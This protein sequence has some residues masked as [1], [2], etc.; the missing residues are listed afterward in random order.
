M[1]ITEHFSNTCLR[2]N[3]KIALVDIKK[4]YTFIDIYNYAG[5]ISAYIHKNY[6]L[7]GD[8]IGISINGSA[9]S[10]ILILGIICS[11]NYYIPINSENPQ[12]LINETIALTNPKLLLSPNNCKTATLIPSGTPLV[13]INEILN[14]TQEL[15]FKNVTDE[16][17]LYAI[18]TSGSTGHPKIILKNHLSMDEFII[19]FTHCFD[20]DETENIGNQIPFYSDAAQKE[21]YLLIYTGCRIT[22][23]PQYYFA[24]PYALVSYINSHNITILPWVPSAFDVIVKFNILKKDTFNGLKC[25]FWVGERIKRT[26]I[27]YWRNHFPHV[28]HV[29]IYGM[30]EL[31]GIC[32]YYNMNTELP[33]IIP[34][35]TPLPHC[36]LTFWDGESISSQG[37]LLISSCSLATSIITERGLQ[38]IDTVTLCYNHHFLRFYKTGDYGYLDQS[39]NYVITG[40]RDNMI[41]ING[42]RIDTSDIERT[43]ERNTLVDNTSI[44]FYDNQLFAFVALS[45]D[46]PEA[47]KAL[48]EFASQNLPRYSQPHTY[49]FLSSIPLNKNGKKDKTSLLNKLVL[50]EFNHG[51]PQ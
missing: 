2:M 51:N 19:N 20:I 21:L 49:Y 17:P 23:I 11:G 34:I 3:N 45:D 16:S 26:S 36:T 32:T 31:A 7:C 33:E 12:E 9:E 37:E 13:F 46:F 42:Y 28:R 14:C 48:R 27:E 22:M 43:L 39:G 50:G 1:T 18:L 25:T 47:R 5:K 4:Q 30:S 8:G 44:I 10:L 41:K 35:G 24:L 6:Q 38:T 15:L 40:R 29:N